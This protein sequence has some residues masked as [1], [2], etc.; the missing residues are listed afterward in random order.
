MPS[1]N[2]APPKRRVFPRQLS[3]FGH[4][5][6]GATAI[7]FA[8]LA[9]PFFALL[10][11]TLESALIFFAGQALD[12]ATGNAARMIRTGQAQQQKFDEAKFKASICDRVVLIPSCTDK[13]NLDVR[14]AAEF[15]SVDLGSPVANG[16]LNTGNF[17]FDPGNG[18]D[19]V[20]VRAFYEWPTI[21]RIVGDS[22][23]TLANGNFLLAGTAA[24][25]NEP[26][27]W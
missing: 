2:K 20:V 5:Q 11:I 14:T 24:F 7:E 6:S 22:F 3:R 19:I 16:E 27:P 26:F 12:A 1:I 10:F 23:P 13:L 9:L 8:I 21:T 4:D 17:G 18:G 15:D 25:R